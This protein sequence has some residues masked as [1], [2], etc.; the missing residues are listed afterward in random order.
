M[1]GALLASIIDMIADLL[2]LIV[3]V[4]VIVSYLLSPY[5]PVRSSLDRIV[6]PMLAPLRRWIPPVG[7]LDFTPVVLI[8][9]IQVAAYLLRMFLV[10]F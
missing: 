3:I 8:I 2:I 4:D 9:L 5:H 10:R 7:V 6:Q 1:I